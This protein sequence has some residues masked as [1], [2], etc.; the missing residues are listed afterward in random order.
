MP[1]PI[2]GVDIIIEGGGGGVMG[3]D[4]GLDGSFQQGDEDSMGN[5]LLLYVE[6]VMVVCCRSLSEDGG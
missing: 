6:T 3:V 1:V 5:P 4:G 2:L